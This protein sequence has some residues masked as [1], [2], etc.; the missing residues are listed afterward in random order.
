VQLQE[1][2]S[3]E[4]RGKT[5]PELPAD[6]SFIFDIA[7]ATVAVLREKAEDTLCNT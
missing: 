5:V 1:I 2:S 3:T 4:L 6:T 7:S